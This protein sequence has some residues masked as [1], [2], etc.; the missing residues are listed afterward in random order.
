MKTLTPR[1]KS[2]LDFIKEY[3][4]SRGYSPS[5]REIQEHFGF[6]SLGSVYKYVNILKDRG[7]LH[8]EKSRSRSMSL[9]DDSRNSKSGGLVGITFMGYLSL[10]SGLETLSQTHTVDLPSV[11]VPNPGDSYALRA[12]GNFGLDDQIRDGD[13]LVIETEQN[14]KSGDLTL[15]KIEEGEIALRSYYPEGKYVRLEGGRGSTKSVIFK[16]ENLTVY[17]VLVGLLRVY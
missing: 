1:Q 5:Y 11:L 16:R 12:R 4:S 13:L 3:I 9:L 2:V 7:V 17:G 15:V 6:N 10:E 14:P 8:S